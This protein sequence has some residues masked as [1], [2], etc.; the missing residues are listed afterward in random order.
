MIPILF[1][2]VMYH[3]GVETDVKAYNGEC[4]DKTFQR[5]DPKTRELPE[6]AQRQ[7]L[8]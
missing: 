4:F 1:E 6:G 8:R 2:K 3:Q 7:P 5:I